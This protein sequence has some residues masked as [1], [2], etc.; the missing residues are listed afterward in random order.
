MIFTLHN[1]TEKAVVEYH[2]YPS[3]LPYLI[4]RVDNKQNW[5]L[6]IL[7]AEPIEFRV[8]N[9]PEI[10]DPKL[11]VLAPNVDNKAGVQWLIDNDI[12]ESDTIIQ[13]FKGLNPLQKDTSS[14]KNGYLLTE[15][16][17]SKL[18]AIH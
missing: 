4:V 18:P 12:I 3:G 5:V 10:I 14:F 1:Q 17:F 6:E 9:K 7:T 13:T 11:I 8:P 2:R 15:N 16:A